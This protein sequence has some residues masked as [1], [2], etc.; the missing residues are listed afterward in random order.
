[1]TPALQNSGCIEPNEPA[2]VEQLIL[3]SGEWQK[4]DVGSPQWCELLDDITAAFAKMGQTLIS[5]MLVYDVLGSASCAAKA[6]GTG[7]ATTCNI[8]TDLGDTVG[9]V[10]AAIAGNIAGPGI[11]SGILGDLPGA[12]SAALGIPNIQPIIKL[13]VFG[14]LKSLGLPKEAAC[15]VATGLDPGFIIRYLRDTMC[16]IFRGL[17]S[18]VSCNPVVV[19]GLV[20]CKGLLGS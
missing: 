13:I 6:D 18:G 14:L 20:F 4:W 12:L 3:L 7:D 5:L 1:M 15:T 10:L 19:S 8:E 9:A 16:T 11:L 2:P 17:Q